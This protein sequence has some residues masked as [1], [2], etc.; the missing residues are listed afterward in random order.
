MRE[1][2]FM[3]II[4]EI[5]LPFAL[6]ALFAWVT[7][8]HAVKAIKDVR[9]Y[10]REGCIVPAKVTDFHM[11]KAYNG[12]FRYNRFEVTV[13]CALPD[14]ISDERFLLTT[15]SHRGKRYKD[16][17]DT[18]VVFLSLN[19]KSPILKEELCHIRRMRFTAM[20]GGVISVMFCMLMIIAVVCELLDTGRLA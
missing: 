3:G 14:H 20:L 15:T 12:S 13:E 9:R 8:S 4:K 16:L 5:V 6:F 7:I 11:Y 17:K 18:E 19:D 1:L 10:K 2:G